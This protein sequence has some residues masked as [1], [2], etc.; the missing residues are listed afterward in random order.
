MGIMG[1]VS[2]TGKPDVLLCMYF[3]TGFH[4]TPD[5]FKNYYSA[6]KCFALQ[7]SSIVHF[8]GGRTHE[9]KTNLEKL[10]FKSR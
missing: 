8:D 9:E 2:S 5:C 6:S 7:L 4:L 10:T 3:H 1:N